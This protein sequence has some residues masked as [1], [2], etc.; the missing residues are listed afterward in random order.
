MSDI[1]NP[2]LSS[3]AYQM[4]THPEL[5]EFVRIVWEEAGNAAMVYECDQVASAVEQIL[6]NKKLW[7][8]VSP[9]QTYIEIM[10]A[11][12]LLFNLVVKQDDWTTLFK[13]RML[14]QELARECDVADAICD[15]LFQTI[16][17]QM[18]EFTPVPNVKPPANTPSDFFALAVWLV[19][20][21]NKESAAQWN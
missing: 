16:E 7:V 13:P 4:I 18:G 1:S 2:V 19:R 9:K 14:W 15:A 21:Y 6:R 11:A 8:S 5:K 3:K 20:S 12:S 10:L 17:A